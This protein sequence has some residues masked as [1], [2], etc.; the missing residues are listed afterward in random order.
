MAR[1]R[2]L[3][4]LPVTMPLAAVRGALDAAARTFADALSPVGG[5]PKAPEP[6]WEG[7]DEQS[8]REIVARLSGA[9]DATRAAVRRYEAANQNR[10]TVLRAARLTPRA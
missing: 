3:L 1:M 10:A 9:G 8:A 4:L 7:Y 5:E 6:P 2:K